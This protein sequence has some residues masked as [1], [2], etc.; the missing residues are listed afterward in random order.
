M[1]KYIILIMLVP[2]MFACNSPKTA[3]LGT[4]GN[5][6]PVLPV[7]RR[8][9]FCLSMLSNL[10]AATAFS[11]DTAGA[12][13][14]I[15]NYSKPK[16]DSVLQFATDTSGGEN[17]NLKS[18]SRVWGPAVWV[19]SG[20]PMTA[21]TKG[22]WVSSNS[23]TIFKDTANNYVMAIQATNPYCPYD[24][25]TLDFSVVT[26]VSWPY[27]NGGGNISNGT[28]IGL[29][30]LL[31]MVD[32]SQH[33]SA[34]TYMSNVTASNNTPV[35]IVVTGHSLGGA[36]APVYALRL[37]E[38][39]DT[40]TKNTKPNIYCLATA[41]ATPGDS[42]FV[43]YYM[44]KDGGV[45]GKNTV[46]I[47]NNLDV[48]PHAWVDSLLTK[49]QNGIYDIPGGSVPYDSAYNSSC[50]NGAP[51]VAFTPIQTPL[52]IQDII[53]GVKK[54]ISLGMFLPKSKKYT[55]LCGNGISFTGALNNTTG[56]T[57]SPYFRVA[58]D[59]ALYSSINYYLK[60]I[61]STLDKLPLFS[62]NPFAGDTLTPK[63]STTFF[64][65]L[66]AQHVP[67]YNLYFN[68]KGIHNFT[69]VL[70]EQDLN[71]IV[72]YCPTVNTVKKG[73]IQDIKIP[74]GITPYAAIMAAGLK[75]A[76]EW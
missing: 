19:T 40:A 75:K 27:N 1:K 34:L 12:I 32:D 18:W 8:A 38:Y 30:N 17:F 42:S 63:D 24:W 62:K 74:A 68:V 72:N 23:M 55:Q 58:P 37:Q 67:A 33:I 65:Q 20:D 52:V 71:S 31:G 29:N 15:I 49:V 64:T 61:D 25:L 39:F 3:N 10:P 56:N 41:G 14:S 70:V 26:T 48:I 22:T 53:G 35:N 51:P 66:G 28:F 16:I 73:K 46:R 6:D 54:V 9:V 76:W 7:D 21:A 60:K 59:T 5:N 4:T 50:K 2:T 69:R 57:S 43:Q 11:G 44:N 13:A 36:L 45:L 47:W